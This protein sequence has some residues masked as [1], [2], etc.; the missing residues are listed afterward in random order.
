M[1]KKYNKSRE[2]KPNY[3]KRG[4][5][6]DNIQVEAGR[7]F[8]FEEKIREQRNNACNDNLNTDLNSCSRDLKK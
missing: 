4:K 6:L 1:A 2:Q 8:D 5:K 7:E 3:S